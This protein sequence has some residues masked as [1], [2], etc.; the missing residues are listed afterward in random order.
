[1]KELTLPLLAPKATVS[2]REGQLVSGVEER[3]RETHQ[4]AERK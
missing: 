4:G 1:M 3:K 2:E